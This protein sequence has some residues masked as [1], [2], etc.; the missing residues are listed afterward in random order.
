[1][2]G[3]HLISV[4]EQRSKLWRVWQLVAALHIPEDLTEFESRAP[5]HNDDKYD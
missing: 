1:M 4:A 3:P 2:N 5:D